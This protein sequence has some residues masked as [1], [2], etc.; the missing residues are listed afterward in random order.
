M[1]Q[2]KLKQFANL[3]KEVVTDQIVL[4]PDNQGHHIEF[5]EDIDGKGLLWIGQGYNKQII[6]STNPDRFF[7]SEN[8]DLAKGK[9]LSINNLK[10]LNE[11]ELGTSITKSSLKEVGRLKG[12]IVDGTLSVNNYLYFD[13][14]TDRL[15]IG[16]ENPKTV[17]D[18]VDNDVEILIGSSEPNIGSIGT[19]G[20]Q[21]FQ[22]RT[23]N[24]ARITVSS[25]G[26]I[27]LG[28]SNT[29]PTHVNVIGK[30]SVNVNTPDSR[31][32]LHVNGPIKFSNRIHIS[33][34]SAPDGGAYSAGDICWHNEP[35]PG[36][37]VGWVCVRSGNPGIW[38]PFGRID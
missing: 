26:T 22:I 32:S 10:V 29:G 37:H 15:G 34:T 38:H 6:F 35:N 28:N 14:H 9:H 7:I 33:G 16:T 12:L 30:L 27:T 36:S 2:E 3:L 21:D 1:D 5:F 18:L 19:F 8:I 17:L 20:S 31:A 25:G 13:S 11:T 24:T 4:S 23:D